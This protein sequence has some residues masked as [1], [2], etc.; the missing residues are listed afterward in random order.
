MTRL[1]HC[2]WKRNLSW[3]DS[4]SINKWRDSE[5]EWWGGGLKVSLDKHFVFCWRSEGA[6]QRI[7]RQINR[8]I[9]SGFSLLKT[10]A[11]PLRSS[12]MDLQKERAMKRREHEDKENKWNPRIKEWIVEVEFPFNVANQMSIWVGDSYICKS[13]NETV[14]KI[15]TFKYTDR[16]RDHFVLLHIYPIPVHFQDDW[17]D[18][19]LLTTKLNVPF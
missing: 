2:N 14:S 11:C 10:R 1:K 19:P 8:L 3:V 13:R 7:R 17:L 15:R 18:V 6:F 5:V 4:F 9:C 12:W 16:T